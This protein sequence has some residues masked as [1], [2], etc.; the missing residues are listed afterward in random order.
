MKIMSK[1]MDGDVENM[2]KVIKKVAKQVLIDK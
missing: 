2:N 1:V